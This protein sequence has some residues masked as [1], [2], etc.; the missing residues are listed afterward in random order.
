MI[1]NSPPEES[2]HR[3]TPGASIN[4][5]SEMIWLA[6][7]SLGLLLL[8]IGAAVS[9][10]NV[11]YAG[12]FIFPFSLMLG[13]WL[14]KNLWLRITL[15]VVGGLFVIGAFTSLGLLSSLMRFGT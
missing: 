4:I 10:S 6:G 3:R 7:A 15:I 2:A 14:E 11:S 1:Y 8:V 13:S 12:M 9:S 5:N